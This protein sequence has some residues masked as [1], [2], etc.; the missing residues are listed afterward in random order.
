MEKDKKLCPIQMSRIGGDMHCGKKQ[1]AWWIEGDPNF[2]DC[3][4][5]VSIRN[6]VERIA[7]AQVRQ[8]DY[9]RAE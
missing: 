5:V 3:C 8:A 4:T 9:D 1:C 7:K 6:S 2:E